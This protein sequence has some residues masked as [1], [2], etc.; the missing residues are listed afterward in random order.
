MDQK[1]AIV[2][3]ASSGFGFLA[4][5]EL[6]KKGFHVIATVRTI[7]KGAALLEQASLQNVEIVLYELDVACETSLKQWESY[8]RQL[9]RVDVLVNNA[10]FAMGGF[11]EEIS[12]ASYKKQFETNFFGAISVTQAVLPLMRK[13]QS[14]YIIN[15]SSI[16]GL[17]GFPGLSPYVASKH[18]LE[19]WSESLRLELRPFGIHVVLIEPGSFQTN[20][21]S[22]GREV[23]PSQPDSPYYT[24]MQR[25]EQHIS[26]GSSSLGNPLEVAQKIIRI[27]ETTD[28][29]LRYAVGK[30]VSLTIWIKKILPWRIWEKLVY[31]QLK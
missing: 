17:I 19:G 6:A 12:I 1:V 31:R 28:P 3:G 8:V 9:H 5:L 30:G 13:R 2:T 21:W 15:M 22:S 4:A 16:S 20:I 23:S 27:I 29:S 14:G 25:L 18:A 26:A 24:Y 7:E 10:G 11:T